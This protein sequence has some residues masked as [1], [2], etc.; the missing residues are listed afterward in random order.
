MNDNEKKEMLFK[1]AF[2]V[3]VKYDDTT[4]VIRAKEVW[5]EYRGLFKAIE[6]MG[7]V[8]EFVAYCKKMGWDVTIP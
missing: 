6:I 1:T 7:L 2:R 3:F 5:C 4:D 8:T